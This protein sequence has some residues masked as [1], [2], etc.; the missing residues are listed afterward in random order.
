MVSIG[1]SGAK[2]IVRKFS[3]LTLFLPKLQAEK[4]LTPPFPPIVVANID[5][6]GYK[7]PSLIGVG[8]GWERI[9]A[10]LDGHE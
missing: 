7:G 8:P 3:T 5:K 9:D 4:R 2:G 1:G 6:G 10:K